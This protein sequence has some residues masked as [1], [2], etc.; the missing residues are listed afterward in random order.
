MNEVESLVRDK[1]NREA[2]YFVDSTARNIQSTYCSVPSLDQAASGTFV[3]NSTAI[4]GV[5]KRLGD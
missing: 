5:F 2:S 3:A 1:Q 4:H